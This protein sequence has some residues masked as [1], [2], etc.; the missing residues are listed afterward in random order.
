MIIIGCYTIMK[1]AIIMKKTILK[2]SV[3]LVRLL[4]QIKYVTSYVEDRKNF[5]T[6]IF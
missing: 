4:R 6:I 5:R 1:Q 2:V 3:N